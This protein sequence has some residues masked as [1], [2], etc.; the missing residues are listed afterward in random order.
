LLFIINLVFV[1]NFGVL[2]PY[3][4]RCFSNTISRE[5]GYSLRRLF[6][7][8]AISREFVGLY[9]LILAEIWH[10]FQANLRRSLFCL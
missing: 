7:E 8:V 5:N 1:F 6:Y 4:R 10:D 9:D 2:L 3:W